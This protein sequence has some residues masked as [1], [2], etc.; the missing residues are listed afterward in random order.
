MNVIRERER[1]SSHLG[2]CKVLRCVY[3]ERA[4][5]VPASVVLTFTLRISAPPNARM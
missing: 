5:T 3:S 1:A 4:V 2:S